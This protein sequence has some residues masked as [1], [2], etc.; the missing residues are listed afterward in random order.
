MARWT[1][2]TDWNEVPV[3]IDPAFIARLLQRSVRSV[4]GM[5]TAGEIPGK[6]IGK[7]W[8]ISRDQFRSWLEGGMES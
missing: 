4:T 3:V 6:K 8:R 2:T 1:V 7:T 5:L